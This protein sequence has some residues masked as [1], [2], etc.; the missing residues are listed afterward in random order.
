[1]LVAYCTDDSTQ[2]DEMPALGLAGPAKGKGQRV[3]PRHRA[4]G[5]CTEAARGHP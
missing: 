4:G 3:R 2:A 5:D 1:M